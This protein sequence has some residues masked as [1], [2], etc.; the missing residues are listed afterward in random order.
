V[1]AQWPLIGRA[2]EL[3]RLQG[4]RP[5]SAG[6]V[7][8]AGPAGVGKTRLAAEYL[9]GLERS[10]ASIA[11]VSATR[12]GTSLPLG[13]FAPLLPPLTS[14]PESGVDDR[15]DLLRRCA[16]HIVE[17]AAGRP[18]VLSVDDAHLLDDLSATL[19]HQMAATGAALVVATLRS[20]EP[21]PDPIVALWKDDAVERLE[22]SGLDAASVEELLLAVLG[23]PV[24]RGTVHRLVIGSQGNVLFLRE[25]VL[26]ALD[27]GSLANDVGIW[28]LTGPLSPSS[29]LSELVET[30]LAG[31]TPAER[32]LLEVLAF[33]EPLGAAEIGLLG[34]PALA[35]TLERRGLLASRTEGR[36]LEVR[37]GHSLY[38]EVIRS[39]TP[40]LRAREVARLLADTVEA[41]G[42]RRRE[43]VLRVATW[44]LSGGTGDPQLMYEAAR[45]ARWRYDFPL[46]ERLAAA[47]VQAG[48]GFDAALLVAQLASLQG[49]GDE[50]EQLLVVLADEVDDDR[51]RGLVACTRLDNLVFH[52]GRI[53]AGLAMAEEAER[54]IADPAWRDELVAKR[55]AIIDGQYGPRA[56]AAVALPLLERGGGRAFVWASI[57]TAY[58]TARMGRLDEARAIADRGYRAHQALT[59]PFEWH[60]WTHT[61]FRAEAL[62]H[63]GRFEE[64]GELTTEQYQR[65]LDEK[66][67][68]AQAWFAWQLAKTAAD[69]GSPRTAAVHGRAAVALFRE[70][71]Q[72]QFESFALG[73]LA[74]AEA[75]SGDPDA[76]TEALARLDA[77]GLPPVRYYGVDLVV[78]RA[79]AMV[80]ARD[81]P[82]AIVLLKEA[83][84]LG[85][86]IGDLVGEAIARHTLARLG[87]ASEVADGLATLGPSVEGSLMTA[88]V[89]HASALAA[90]DQE[91]LAEVSVEFE[92]MGAVL[93]AAE[94]AAD[95]AVAW[96]RWGDPRRAARAEQRADA[97]AATC[98]NPVTPALLAIKSRSRLT[99]AERETALL[100]AAGRSNKEI[101]AQLGISVRTVE[102]H[103][104][105]VYEKLGISA[106]TDLPQGLE[107]AY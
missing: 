64:A 15:A 91:A 61:F 41:T 31:L 56:G 101:A 46:A 22:L 90:N 9:A 43:D 62:A 54:H 89:A 7:V 68:E 4:I 39:R 79:W 6:G 36:R 78:A 82:A 37:L 23:G 2:G 21:A 19:V 66:S 104:Q 59:E 85:D 44:R 13:A 80:A 94:A 34:D 14:G 10:G 20:I 42:A 100:A 38:G 65:A 88:R 70:L 76:A 69:R 103:L 32:N 24:D 50:A 97:L 5:G 17:S 72:P 81:L 92:A 74:Q 83:V 75:L 58:S 55:A 49:R 57:I 99:Q 93:L 67:P 40:A 47:A 3:R 87:H 86:E 52:M 53:D 107:Q 48:G 26:G 29:R 95:S 30:R 71:G 25:L 102:N 12:A 11:R 51:Q 98:E 60:P 106:R 1:G 73:A 28:R 33:G 16:G 105:H 45:L 8:L 63:G 27:D 35:E 77:L 96:R 84:V 18:L